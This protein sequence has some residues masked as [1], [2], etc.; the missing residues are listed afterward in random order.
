M[1]HPVVPDTLPAEVAVVVLEPL[2]A[3]PWLRE[4]GWYAP[5]ATVRPERIPGYR[6]VAFSTVRRRREGGFYSRR[7][8]FVKA[9][10]RA[11]YG[12]H[13]WPIE[14]VD[15]LS[16]APRRASRPKGM[17]PSRTALAQQQQQEGGHDAAIR[18]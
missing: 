10:D 4:H 1:T 14:A 9:D 3:Y 6:I 18:P 11:A 17:P 7:V 16:I 2:D 8:W 15:P 12:D 5:G 13:D